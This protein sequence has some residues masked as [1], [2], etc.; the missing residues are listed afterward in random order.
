MLLRS[1]KI[2]TDFLRYPEAR[3]YLRMGYGIEAR[4]ERCKHFWARHLELC[5]DFQRQSLKGRQNTDTLAVL[6]AGRL[7]DLA[8]PD[9]LEKFSRIDLFDRDPSANST[10]QA[11]RNKLKTGV[12]LKFFN[13]DLSSSIQGW[14][15][16]L[17]RFLK[18]QGKPDPQAIA[19]FLNQLTPQDSLRFEHYDTIFSL[20][21]LSQIPIYWRDRVFSYLSDYCGVQTDEH[22]RFEPQLQRALETSQRR[23]EMQH[24]NLLASSGAKQ[25]VLISDRY[26]FYYL[27]DRAEWQVEPALQLG[28]SLALQG[29]RCFA[30]NSWLWHIAPQDIE[31][32]GYGTIHEVFAQAFSSESTL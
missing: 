26:F 2:Y 21:L 14:S 4:Y 12:Q 22:G 30:E 10:W 20:N 25:I 16:A 32:S 27:K 19:A 24:L 1:L 28:T 3:D 15:K 6:G 9:I 5:K 13:L 29:Y 31:Q 17:K 23:L 8:L 18:Q 7:Y 11:L